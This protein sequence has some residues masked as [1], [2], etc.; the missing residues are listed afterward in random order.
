M[1]IITDYEENLVDLVRFSEVP[2]SGLLLALAKRHAARLLGLKK[3][4]GA[5]LF[6]IWEEIYPSIFSGTLSFI[7][8]LTSLETCRPPF[9]TMAS[10]GRVL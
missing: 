10:V 2:C 6:G 5:R 4:P 9:L 8:A 1:N 7:L 3:I